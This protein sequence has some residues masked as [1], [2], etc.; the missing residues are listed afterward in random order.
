MSTHTGE[1]PPNRSSRGDT[2]L[3]RTYS[4]YREGTHA[5]EKPVICSTHGIP[6]HQKGNMTTCARNQRAGRKPSAYPQGHKALPGSG[7]QRAK[8]PTPPRGSNP[9]L[10]SGRHIPSAPRRATQPGPMAMGRR[11]PDGMTPTGTMAPSQHNREEASDTP[12]HAEL[13]RTLTSYGGGAQAVCLP[14]STSPATPH[15]GARSRSKE[16]P[17]PDSASTREARPHRR[18]LHPGTDTQHDINILSDHTSAQY[19]QFLTVT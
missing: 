2:P 14:R 7:L 10:P 18:S 11:S 17:P 1:M 5:G 9:V 12:R 13:T 3:E 19:E 16:G 8:G 15:R 4:R 6:H